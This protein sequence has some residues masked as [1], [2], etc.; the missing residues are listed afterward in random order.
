MRM[1]DAFRKSGCAAAVDDVEEI[2]VG[3]F[4][5]GWLGI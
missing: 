5:V 4:N 2:V 1:H 3:D